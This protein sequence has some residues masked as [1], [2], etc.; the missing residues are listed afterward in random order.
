MAINYKGPGF[1][2]NFKKL[3]ADLKPMTW[4]QR[5]D[6]IWTY[7][8]PHM[9]V[10]LLVVVML[11]GAI[12]MGINANKKVLVS[13]VI[14]NIS[15]TQ[16]GRNYLEQD[17]LKDLGG[18]ERKES[19]IVYSADFS[20]LEDAVYEDEQYSA[21]QTVIALVAGAKLDYMILDQFAMEFYIRQDVYFDLRGFFSEEELA[22]LEAAG[23]VIFAQEEG[24][25]DRMPIAVDISELEFVKENIKDEQRIFFAISGNTP[26]LEMCRD[27]YN[28]I[29]AWKIPAQ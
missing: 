19:V 14:V 16:E 13:G 15:M 2:E 28:R 10:G 26:D 6:H 25:E 29:H 4:K 20:S 24:K 11:F 27:V 5:V 7:Y 22:E 12:N 17:Y 23:L 8:R 18:D 3:L 21:A 9:L 1:R